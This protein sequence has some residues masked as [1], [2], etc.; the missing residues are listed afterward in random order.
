MTLDKGKIEINELIVER[1]FPG[2]LFGSH[3]SKQ[4][5]EVA[6]SN[7]K[8]KTPQPRCKYNNKLDPETVN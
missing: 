8:F 4:Y 7:Q 2:T 1:I 3:D 5:V 6:Q